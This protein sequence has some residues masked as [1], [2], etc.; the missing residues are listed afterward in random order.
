MLETGRPL[1]RARG[2]GSW[3]WWCCWPLVVV[4]FHSGSMLVARRKVLAAAAGVGGLV[5]GTCRAVVGGVVVGTCWAGVGVLVV[6]TC[7]A[8]VGTLP[9]E[10]EV[11]CGGVACTWGEGGWGRERGGGAWVGEEGMV[12]GVVVR[13]ASGRCLQAV[14]AG[15]CVRISK[16]WG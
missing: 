5:V 16:W 1:V 6:G 14:A 3:Q 15:P 4:P 7:R 12:S 9:L 10:G 8:V 11:T 2:R 13:R